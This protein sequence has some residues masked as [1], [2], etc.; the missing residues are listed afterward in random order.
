[1]PVSH[2]PPSLDFCISYGFHSV[3]CRSISVTCS[4]H[5][6]SS[7]FQLFRVVSAIVCS[8]S[9]MASSST[10]V[11]FWASLRQR[12]SRAAGVISVRRVHFTYS[13]LTQAHSS[14]PVHVTV[15]FVNSIMMPSRHHL[16]S[17]SSQPI[18]CPPYTLLCFTIISS[19]SWEVIIGKL[20]STLWLVHW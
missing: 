13:Q 2:I 11:I 9:H 12:T 5:F 20:E 1:M 19:S 3:S 16:E 10:F 7:S 15:V 6:F 18:E 4:N 17:G 8:V 14:F